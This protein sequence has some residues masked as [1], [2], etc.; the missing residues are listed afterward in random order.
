MYV[1]TGDK[2]ITYVSLASFPALRRHDLATCARPFEAPVP[3]PPPLPLKLS[4]F[5]S[6]WSYCGELQ[7]VYQQPTSGSATGITDILSQNDYP[8]DYRPTP[9]I[10]LTCQQHPWFKVVRHP[11]TLYA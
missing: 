11:Y 9:P 1:T 4:G 2:A 3:P 6:V 10:N 8:T 5:T 7:C